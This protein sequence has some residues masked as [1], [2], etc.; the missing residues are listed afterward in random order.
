[1]HIVSSFHASRVEPAQ[2]GTVV[3]KYLAFE[4][5]RSH[6]RVFV[7]RFGMLAMLLGIV[8]LGLHWLSVLASWLSVGLC[9]VPPAWAWIAELRSDARLTRTLNELPGGATHLVLPRRA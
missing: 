7:A 3:A 4:R 5:A 1:M 2:I 8:G 6:R 9:A